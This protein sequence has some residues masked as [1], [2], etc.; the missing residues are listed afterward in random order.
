MVQGNQTSSAISGTIRI[1]SFS[2]SVFRLNSLWINLHKTIN[3]A[4]LLQLEPEPLLH[5]I[6][7]DAFIGKKLDYEETIDDYCIAGSFYWI[8]F[9]SDHPD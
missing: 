1:L 7:E 9:Q 2:H 8:D 5:K 3:A 6:I 4:Y